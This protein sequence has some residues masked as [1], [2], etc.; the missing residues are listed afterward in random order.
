MAEEMTVLRD[1]QDRLEGRVTV[2]EATV[3]REAALRAKMD[4]DQSNLAATL[5][6]HGRSLQALHDT[7]QDH[8][9]RLTRIEGD[10]SD[11][12]DRLGNVEVRLGNVEVRLGNV[13]EDLV[14]VKEKLDTV[15]IGVHA[16][17]D[18]LDTHL[19]RKP[20]LS[21]T[22]LLRRAPQ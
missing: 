2:L 14:T 20:R 4:E 17:L 1:R 16:I 22:G 9:R 12:K 13:E 15:H 21:L 5:K 8:T 7:Q 18:L 3:E 11:V 19:A 6:A 10:L